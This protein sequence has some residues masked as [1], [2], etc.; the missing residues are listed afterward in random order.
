[1][2][3]V[4]F[5]LAFL[6]SVNLFAQSD[7][8]YFQYR[9]GIKQV[10]SIG[11]ADLIKEPLRDFFEAPVKYQEQLQMFILQSKVEV[12]N[13][14]VKKFLASKGYEDLIYFKKEKISLEQ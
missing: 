9:I 10:T 2:K 6:T 5:I 8:S 7:T 13:F 4:L 1:M 11:S 12:E 3:S 14:E